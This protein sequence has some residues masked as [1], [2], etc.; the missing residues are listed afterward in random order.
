[1]HHDTQ[2]RLQLVTETDV[3]SIQLAANIVWFRQKILVRFAQL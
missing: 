2:H 1:M 3:Y